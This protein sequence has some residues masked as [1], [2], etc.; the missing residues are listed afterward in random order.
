MKGWIT[1]AALVLMT[2]PV[3]AQ[4]AKTARGT[5]TALTDDSL[6]VN[7]HDHAMTFSI[8]RATQVTAAPGER[9]TAANQKSGL[10]PRLSDAFKVGQSVEVSYHD[11][12]GTLHA[13]G[14]RAVESGVVKRASGTVK[15][16]SSA[17]LTITSSGRDMPFVI[18]TSTHITAAGAST[19]SAAVGGKLMITD[20]VKT[21]D[22][23]TVTYRE[24]AGAPLAEEV[25]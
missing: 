12:G 20:A 23:V 15:T 16:V 7:V 5:V 10:A 18:E 24:S 3:V 8:D 9:R 1:A 22:R 25:R 6:T 17:S 2:L 11:M 19:A 21:G 13:A 14:V 4:E